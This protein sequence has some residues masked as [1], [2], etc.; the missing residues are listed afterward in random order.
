MVLIVTWKAG[1]RVPSPHELR[2][3]LQALGDPS[4]CLHGDAADTSSRRARIESRRWGS[5]KTVR[6]AR[7][8]QMKGQGS[9]TIE[10]RRR[11]VP[12]AFVAGEV[13]EVGEDGERDGGRKKGA[14]NGVERGQAGEEVGGGVE[15]EYS[16]VAMRCVFHCDDDDDD[17]AAA[18][19][20][21]E[22]NHSVLKSRSLPA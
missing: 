8:K 1:C 17:D 10:E 16:S 22:R 6:P 7:G 21:I 5:R 18:D 4:I 12:V 9:R 14:R 2:T 11:Q 13:G 20:V 3:L 19:M 15:G